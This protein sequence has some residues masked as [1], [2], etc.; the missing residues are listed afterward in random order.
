MLFVLVIIVI[1][2]IDGSWPNSHKVKILLHLKPQ[3]ILLCLSKIYHD[4]RKCSSGTHL[5]CF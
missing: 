2:I 4:Y 1:I 3:C 5:D